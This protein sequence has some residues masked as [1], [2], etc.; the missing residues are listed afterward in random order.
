MPLAPE[1]SHRIDY[2]KVIDVEHDL[3]PDE[4]R[5]VGEGGQGSTQ[6]DADAA[7][8]GNG[9]ATTNVN[10]EP[11]VHPRAGD[12]PRPRSVLVPNNRVPGVGRFQDWWDDLSPA[13]LEDLLSDRQLATTIGNRIRRTGPNRGGEHE[14]LK[15]SQQLTHKRLGFSMREIQDW[16]TGT[17]VAEGPLPTPD[18]FGNTRW[19][20][21]D[22][23]GNSPGSPAMHDALDALYDPPPSS[24][25]EL[26]RRM[27]DF[28]EDYLDSGI[29]SFPEGLRQAIEAAGD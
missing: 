10:D 24:R 19:R 15:V 12:E 3:T 2:D 25:N 28:A 7:E 8:Q 17:R 22:E 11:F 20:H 27:G 23:D 9:G 26:L 5:A 4:R 14:W 6:T 29:D 1:A 16:V 13:E 21:M 18:R